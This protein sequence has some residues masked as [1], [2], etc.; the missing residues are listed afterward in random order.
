MA[1]VLTVFGFL[2][3]PLGWI[4]S[5]WAILARFTWPPIYGFFKGTADAIYAS[6]R[7]LRQVGRSTGLSDKADR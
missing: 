7:K 2:I 6:S 3:L 1:I 5:F 4:F